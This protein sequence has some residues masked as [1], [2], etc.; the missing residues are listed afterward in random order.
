VLDELNLQAST[1]TKSD[2]A[3]IGQLLNADYL[4]LG[5]LNVAGTTYLLNARLLR[6]ET[7]QITEGRRVICEECKG[8]D[9]FDAI[10]LLGT[11]IAQ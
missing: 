9:V 10:H 1:L 8:K 2:G 3:R 6:V 4:I 5:S 7:S 11:T